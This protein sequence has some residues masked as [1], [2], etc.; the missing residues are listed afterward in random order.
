[1]ATMTNY[2]DHDDHDDENHW[3]RP[4]DDCEDSPRMLC[5]YS[6]VRFWVH[7][8][9]ARGTAALASALY[10]K[11]EDEPQGVAHAVYQTILGNNSGTII[12]S[13]SY[14]SYGIAATDA[15]SYVP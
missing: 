1:M 12:I 3:D 15:R 8:A 6:D 5:K 2:D 9:G 7:A 10:S 11:R 4:G 13:Y 14:Y